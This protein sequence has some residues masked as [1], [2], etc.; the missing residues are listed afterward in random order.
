[1]IAPEFGRREMTVFY[2]H[3]DPLR[4]LS[5]LSGI[6]S[7]WLAFARR[8]GAFARRAAGRTGTAFKI[9]HRAVVTAKTR[10]LERELTFPTG[11]HD[12]AKFPQLPL[13]LGEK[14]DL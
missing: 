14:W 8:V 12:A 2:S 1:M 13:I 10:R 5:R 3:Q 6:A 11:S 7:S 9:L 4:D